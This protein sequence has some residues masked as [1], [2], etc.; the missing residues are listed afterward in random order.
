MAIRMTYKDFER[1]E[2]ALERVEP[3]TDEY[4][5]KEEFMEIKKDL[6]G[7]GVYLLWISL[8]LGTPKDADEEAVRH[9]IRRTVNHLFEL[10]SE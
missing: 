9:E 8:H 10:Y 4:P 5:T 7:Y 3:L 6:D 2:T 1:L